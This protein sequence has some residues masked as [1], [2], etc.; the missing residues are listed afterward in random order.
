MTNR[1]RLLV[2]TKKGAFILDSDEA[3]RDWSV[4]GPL[5]EGWPVHDL[6]VEPA[7]RGD[8]GRRRQ[9]VVRAGGLAVRGRR[10]D[11]DALVGRADLRRRRR[12]DR[13][14]L[15][16][17]DDARRRD[18]RRRR[19]GRALPER[20]RRRDLAPRRGPDQPSDPADL[21]PGRR[22]AHP[23][24][25]H[26][27]PDRHRP[28][29]G[30]HLGGRRLRDARR[31][32]RRGRRA[33]SAS[34]PSSTPRTASPRPASASTSS[35]W[36]RASPRRSTSATTAA[37]TAPTT[38]RR[39]GRRS[40]ATCR[41]DF[42]FSMVAHPRDPDTVLGHPAQPGRP[43]PLHAR[44]PRRGLADARPRGVVDPRRQGAADA[45]RL[46]VG[47]ARGDG[48]RHARPGRDHLRDRARASCGTARTRASR[49]G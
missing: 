11:L 4:S 24:H 5:C 3:R 8:P 1:V 41:P 21:G 12:A 6:I 32:R 45:G 34:A 28:D 42:G 23:A 16:P 33:T 20:R 2:G 47:P 9:P 43:G 39:R 25:D 29:V 36:P 30:R 49:G 22:R 27:P 38:A 17:R 18:P 19:A 46:P 48:P 7:Q 40:P 15:V 31:R 13:H 10:L 35:R 26:P 37:S 14:G 44:R